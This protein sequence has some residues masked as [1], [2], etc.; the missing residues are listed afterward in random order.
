MSTQTPQLTQQDIDEAALANFTEVMRR[1][2][3]RSRAKGRDGWHDPELCPVERL[4]SM[5]IGHL[6]KPNE[7]NLVDIAT[8]AMMLHERGARPD[9][10]L[11]AMAAPPSVVPV[12]RDRIRFDDG[13]EV[14][15]DPVWVVEVDGVTIECENEGKA[16]TIASAIN[17]RSRPRADV[18]LI[19]QLRTAL[20][21]LAAFADIPGAGCAPGDVVIS[22]RVEGDKTP[23]MT[24]A[25]ARAARAVSEQAAARRDAFEATRPV[26]TATAA[27]V[28]RHLRAAR[29]E[30]GTAGD[31]FEHCIVSISAI[32][33][34]RCLSARK[35]ALRPDT[36]PT[37]L[38]GWNCSEPS[39][40]LRA[41]VSVRRGMTSSK[42]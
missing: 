3:A 27:A 5:M 36:A 41:S 10:L 16:K 28:G 17:A 21:P 38:T 23:A 4:A 19:S 40:L 15:I 25:N 8:F 24:F 34:F 12:C 35:S 39:S 9:I 26:D 14:E 29:H 33:T 13:V 32:P 42:A 20:E 37:C 7:G 2:L 30:A 1:K 6:G 31:I 22:K 11:Q 18:E